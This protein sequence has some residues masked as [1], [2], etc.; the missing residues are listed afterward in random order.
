[1]KILILDIETAPNLAHVWGLWQQNIGLPQIQEAGYILCWAAKWYGEDEVFFESIFKTHPKTMLKR[2]HK[3]LDEADAVVHYNGTKFDIPTLN[4]EFL[5]YGLPPP[6][7]YKQ[8]DLLKTARSQFK[9]PSNK[10]DYI[11]QALGYEG[12]H[13]HRGHTLWT[14]C[15]KKNPEAWAE[16]EIYN[17]GDVTKLENLYDDF[18]PWIRGHLNHSVI[19]GDLCCPNCGG[20]HYQS[21]GTAARAAGLYRR[22]QCRD[23]FKWFRGNENLAKKEKFI[24]LD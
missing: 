14:E 23:C 12:K 10:L 7:P 2:I 9:F 18:R 16:M 19:S 21:R 17:K 3:L 20:F 13:K 15:M 22:Y 11:L 4:R 6:A 8:I 1:M 5:C 24:A